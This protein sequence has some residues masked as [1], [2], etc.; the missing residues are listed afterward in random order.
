MATLLA[1]PIYCGQIQLAVNAAVMGCDHTTLASAGFTASD[2]PWVS[3]KGRGSQMKIHFV[4]RRLRLHTQLT[5]T[6]EC[7]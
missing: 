6:T 4:S 1:L 5:N 2:V 3:S 7:R